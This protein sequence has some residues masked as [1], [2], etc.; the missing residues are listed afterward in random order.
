[1]AVPAIAAYH[2]EFSKHARVYHGIQK[3]INQG[4]SYRNRQQDFGESKQH[5]SVLV[6]Q[7]SVEVKGSRCE[8][9]GA[10]NADLSSRPQG[11]VRMDALIKYMPQ[12]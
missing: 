8:A 9:Y 4:I 11:V 10:E 1:M 5:H 2:P 6:E 7:A 3:W 12:A